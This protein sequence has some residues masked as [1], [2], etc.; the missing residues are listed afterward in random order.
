MRS[1]CAAGFVFRDHQTLALMEYLVSTT[2]H[3]DPS[4]HVMPEA[5]RRTLV[6]QDPELPPGLTP[7]QRELRSANV[8]LLRI[9]PR[10]KI[11]A[12][13]RDQLIARARAGRDVYA[14]MY[15]SLNPATTQH[16]LL[17]LGRQ[18]EWLDLWIARQ[19]AL[20]IDRGGVQ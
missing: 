15:D 13:M 3:F 4:R 9:I 10:D 5:T 17:V 8:A 2:W 20:I 12:S 11:P 6:A 7:R 1:G 18:I 14:I 16:W 19:Q